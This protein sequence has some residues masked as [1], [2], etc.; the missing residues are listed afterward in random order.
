MRSKYYPR[1]LSKGKASHRNVTGFLAKNGMPGEIRTPDLRI[2]N[3]PLSQLSNGPQR[4]LNRRQSEEKRL[5]HHHQ[6]WADRLRRM[7][8][9]Q[10]LC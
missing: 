4:H 8:D 6:Q 1:L 7:P 3:A 9:S 10:P 2:A 5:F